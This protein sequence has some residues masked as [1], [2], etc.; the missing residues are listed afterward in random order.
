MRHRRRNLLWA[1]IPIAASVLLAACSGSSGSPASAGSSSAKPV[2]GGT[3]TFATSFPQTWILPIWNVGTGIAND[4]TLQS[5]LPLYWFGDNGKAQVNYQLSVAKPPV[6]S[7]NGKTVTI[8]LNPEYKWSNGTPVT[9]RDIEFYINVL[10]A[11]DKAYPQNWIGYSA[12]GFPF[13][14]TSG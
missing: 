11:S 1:L 13:N 8:N 6:F 10:T 14:V 2:N 7:N 9:T 5:W 4:D 12:S 3:A